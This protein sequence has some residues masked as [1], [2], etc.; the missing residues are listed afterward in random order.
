MISDDEVAEPRRPARLT[1]LR[2]DSLSVEELRDYIG[3][4]RAEIE[5]VEAD[6]VRKQTY[7]NAADTFFRK[8]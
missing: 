5:R 6:I 7:R 3:E 8:S 4:L 1:P 2:L